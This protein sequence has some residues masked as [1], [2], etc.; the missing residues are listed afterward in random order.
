MRYTTII[1]ISEYPT[2]YR[3]DAVRLVYLHLVLK[4]GYHDSDRDLCG[5]SLRRIV[6]ETGLTLSSVRCAIK[7]LMAAQLLER[8]GTLWKVKK[9]LLD[10]P[11]TPRAKTEAQAKRRQA[12]DIQEQINQEHRREIALQ[13]E[14]RKRLRQQGKTSFMVFY[15]DQQ[16]KAAKGDPQ[17]AE[18]IKNNEETYK[19][20][21]ETIRKEQQQQ[22]KNQQ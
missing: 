12:E 20:H 5:L 3:S 17:A 15:E 6:Q 18:F 9:Y 11:I 4:A 2:L 13:D 7:R 21:A 16:A 8:Q 1:D 22:Q 14:R 19:M 10:Q